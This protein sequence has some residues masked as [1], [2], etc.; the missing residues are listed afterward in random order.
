MSPL[1]GHLIRP[2]T[3]GARVATTR[4]R[5]ATSE[6]ASEAADRAD[7]AAERTEQAATRIEELGGRLTQMVEALQAATNGER[8]FVVAPAEAAASPSPDELAFAEWIGRF[9]QLEPEGGVY[10]R[11]SHVAD[12]PRQGRGA[13]PGELTHLLDL[14]DPKGPIESEI[15][16]VARA[17]NIYGPS[18]LFR[19][20]AVNRKT[21]QYLGAWE[22]GHRAS[23]H[24]RLA[25]PPPEPGT[26]QGPGATAMSVDPIAAAEKMLEAGKRLTPTPAGA[27][28]DPAEQVAKIIG[29]VKDLGLLPAAAKQED[30]V[31]RITAVVPA[32]K[33][34]LEILRPAPAPDA[35][36]LGVEA[37]R[38][39]GP[40]VVRV[41]DRG[42][43]AFNNWINFRRERLYFE[44][45]ARRVPTRPT[46]R[47]PAAAEPEA[48][49]AAGP[50][51]EL[52][53][54]LQAAAPHAQTNDV[55]HYP[56]LLAGLTT[57][58]PGCDVLL[59]D[60]RAGRVTDVQA[61]DAL[62]ALNIEIL[63]PLAGY[64]RRFLVWAR[65]APATPA[66]P[67][68]AAAA[69][70]EPSREPEIVPAAVGVVGHCDR[71][72]AEYNY[73]TR[74]ELDTDDAPCDAAV[75]GRAC[76]G[77]IVSAEAAP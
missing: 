54:I 36:T 7:H 41:L 57:R 48:I 47:R 75:E 39:I 42:V 62:G 1:N 51:A 46:A 9:Q 14:I 77:R 72:G 23:C 27:A 26:M 24:L 67:V 6:R 20:Q 61:F 56:A 38:I 45:G 71:C 5:V 73:R 64:L 66:P 69:R 52:V 32:I 58:V 34:V 37:V 28:L 43:D 40:P 12:Q 55:T 21:G 11:V 10:A 33:T 31:G 8:P 60:L 74:A 53:A 19:L 15:R 30:L 59:E 35:L 70:A 29:V 65:T 2:G 25:I 49:P 68:P 50:Q 4:A 17:N 3:Q 63:E 18:V 44:S 76:G 13:Q 22:D 16:S